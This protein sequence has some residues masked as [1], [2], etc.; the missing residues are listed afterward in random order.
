M[1]LDEIDA[2][3]ATLEGCRPRRVGGRRG[4]YVDGLLVARVDAPGTILV[5]VDR[6]QREE[7]LRRHAG[8][9]GVPPRWEAHEKVQA[10]LD[11]DAD[12]LREAIT[13][14]WERQRRT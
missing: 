7:L 6:D 12:A 11:G 10:R 1:D 13:M 3:I 8:T 4:W 5:R 9:F 14:A 2:F